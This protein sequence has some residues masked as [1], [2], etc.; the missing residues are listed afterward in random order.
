MGCLYE[1]CLPHIFVRL[2]AV[3]LQQAHKRLKRLLVPALAQRVVVQQNSDPIFG[4]RDLGN[5]LA[6]RGSG[7]KGR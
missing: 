5:G 6:Q 4:A 2:F 1:N 7:R 3:A